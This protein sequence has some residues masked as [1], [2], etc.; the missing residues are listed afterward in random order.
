MD[1]LTVEEVALI[2]KTH[3]NT[4]YKMCRQGVLPA[5]KIGPSWRIERKK[6][7]TFME[8]GTPPQQTDTFKGLASLALQNGHY[9]GIFTREKDILDFELTYFA[10]ALEQYPD[11]CFFKACWWQHPDDIRRHLSSLKIDV[12][13]MEAKGALVI[14]NMSGLYRSGGV[15]GVVEKW[16]SAA[17]LSIKNGFSGLVGTGAKHIDC[18][19]G[20]H[21]PLLEV[22]NGI[23]K[24]SKTHPMTILCTYLMDQTATDIF[25][26]VFEV[27]LM[28]DQFFIQTED[29]EIM[30]KITYSLT[31]PSR[32]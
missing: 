31:H 10:A 5:V 15:A 17:D 23:A 27:T 26:R 9:M 28:H 14:A 12:E 21:H 8:G 32:R 29:T 6:L 19:D 30:A 25:P 24:V 20:K 1:F 16:Q 2:L 4:I 7:A 11:A 13:E 22:E 18:C 3:T